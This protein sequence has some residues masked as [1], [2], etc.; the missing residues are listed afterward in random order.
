V[1]HVYGTHYLMTLLATLMLLHA[2]LNVNSR[3]FS[4]ATV[5]HRLPRDPAPAIRPPL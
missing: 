1:H 5:I 4:T 3:R 2:H